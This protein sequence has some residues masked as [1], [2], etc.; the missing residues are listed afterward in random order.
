[1]KLKYF[2]DKILPA[3]VSRKFV[4]GLYILIAIITGFKQYYKGSFNNYKIFKYTYYHTINQ[5]PLYEN[6]PQQYDDSN[7]YGPVFGLVIAPFALLP[8]FLGTTLWNIANALLLIFGIYSL[9]L[10]LIKRS[11]LGLL[12]AHEALGAMLSFQFNVGLTGLILFSFSYLLKNQ[13]G[14]SAIAIALGTLIKVYGILGLAFFFFTKRKMSFIL[15]GI[16][17]LVILIFLPT[18][19]SSIDFTKQAY[20]DWYSSLVHKNDLNVSLTSGQDISLMGIIRRLLQNPNIPNLPFVIGGLILFLSPYLRINQYKNLAFRF[21]LLASSLIFVVIFS[22][23]SESPT[24]II[25]FTG[26]SIWFVLQDSPKLNWIVVLYIF[27]FILTSLS[28]SDIFPKYIRVNYV[29]HY[30]LKALPCVMV[31]MVIIYQMLTAD[32][33]NYKINIE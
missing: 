3:I 7:H 2:N 16:I 13:V 1:M 4:V 32:F 30:S 22:T 23:G 24:Y 5:Q 14:K 17:S 10:T 26:V 25:A 11:V 6:Y 29:Q 18:F 28:P 21:M 20:I 33:K 19:L 12:C 8:D 27:A 31:W 15:Y 9:P